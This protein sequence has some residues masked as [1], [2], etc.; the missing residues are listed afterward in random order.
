LQKLF[1]ECELCSHILHEFTG[2]TKQNSQR[3]AIQTHE[4]ILALIDEIFI[5]SVTDT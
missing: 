4:M 3:L 5:K 1:S 2:Q